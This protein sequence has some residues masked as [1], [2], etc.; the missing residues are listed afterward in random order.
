MKLAAKKTYCPNCRRL[1]KG[2][3][4]ILDKNLRIL[5]PKCGGVV[6]VQDVLFWR[7]VREGVASSEAGITRHHH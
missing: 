2:Q 3:E 6:W 5:C 4:Q 1:V 7:Y